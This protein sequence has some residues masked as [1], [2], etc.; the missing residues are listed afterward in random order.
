[1][2]GSRIDFFW[3]VPSQ[4][5]RA[6][7]ALGNS[8][9]DEDRFEVVYHLYSI[10]LK[11]RVRVKTRVPEATPEVPTIS[12]LWSAADWFEREA[13]DLF[14]IRFEGHPNLQRLLCHKDFIA[15]KQIGM[16]TSPRTSSNTDPRASPRP[17]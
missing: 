5:D 3:G 9:L 7:A 2:V 16:N 4:N 1:M 17:R 13:Y 15:T 6:V 14:G 12:E 8:A 10:D 11:E